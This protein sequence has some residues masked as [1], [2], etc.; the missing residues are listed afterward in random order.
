[1]RI[2]SP[3]NQSLIKLSDRMNGIYIA[4]ENTV[5]KDFGFI[6][7]C[8]HSENVTSPSE[9][10]CQSGSSRVW[11]ERK[12]AAAVFSQAASD[13]RKFRFARRG[14]GYWL[15]ADAR[16]WITSNDRLWPCSFLNLC[17]VLHLATDVIR[18][19]LLDNTSDHPCLN[20]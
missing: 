20:I 8:L 15:Y 18:A 6:A 19:E 5:A 12:L 2:Q 17:D 14:A 10:G 16:E 7:N 3:R 11:P 4:Q 9:Y 13:L 1:M